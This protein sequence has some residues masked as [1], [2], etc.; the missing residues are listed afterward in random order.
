MRIAIVDLGSNTTRMVI[1]DVIDKQI[2][3]IMNEKEV[4][5]LVGYVNNG[6]LSIDGI[7]KIIETISMF[8]DTAKAVNVDEFHC[9]ATASLRNILN[10]EIVVDKIKLDT[11]I[12]IEVISGEY[13]AY[14]DFAGFNGTAG[15]Q[16]G[17]MIDM[18]GA[19]TEIVK[20]EDSGSKNMVSLSFGS[21]GLYHNFVKNIFPVNKEKAKIKNYVKKQLGTAAWIGE[22]TET[23]FGIGGTVRA[24]AHLH[25]E[26]YH[27][28]DEVEGYTFDANDI[29]DMCN[30]IEKQGV[31]GIKLLIRVIPER[32]HTVIPGMIAFQA[33]I[34]T[35]KCKTFVVSRFGARE[36]YLKERILNRVL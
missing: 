23:I 1:Y 24:I 21:L 25:K 33:I 34:K 4:L 19:S 35:C 2:K 22:E 9:F 27:R 20:F 32:I 31:D 26:I 16:T 17:F 7:H 3:R 30:L 18:G 11:G 29:K 13:E 36:G 14:L 12:D 8:R 15:V 5:G 10:T 6:I 28:D